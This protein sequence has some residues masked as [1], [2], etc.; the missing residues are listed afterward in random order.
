MTAA[1]HTVC[2]I[3]VTSDSI[4]V[5]SP[6]FQLGNLVPRTFMKTKNENKF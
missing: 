5:P 2:S 1:D 6:M 4:S 3:L